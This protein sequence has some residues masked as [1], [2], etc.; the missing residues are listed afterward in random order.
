MFM[1][2]PYTLSNVQT[3]NMLMVRVA[4]NGMHTLYSAAEPSISVCKDCYIWQGLA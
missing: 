4:A 2:L 1:A 3:N